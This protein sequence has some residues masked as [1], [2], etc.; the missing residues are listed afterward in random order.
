MSSENRSNRRHSFT[1]RDFLKTSAAAL[2]VP[3]LAPSSVF[4]AYAPSN[5]VNVAFIGTGNQAKNDLPAFLNLSDVQVLAVCDVN[6]GSRG[7]RDP[8]QFLGREPARKQVNDFYAKKTDA[9]AYRGCDAYVDFREVLA[10]KDIDAVALVAPDHWHGVITC[11]AAAAGKDIYCEKPLSL[12]VRQGRAMIDAVRKHQR[13][14]QTGS[15]YRSSPAV[16]R[17]CELVRNGRLGELRKITT[18]VAKN[19]AVSPPP[20]WK[21]MPVPEG[22]DYQMWLGP[23]PDAP[24]HVDR[25]LYR[26]RFLLDYSGGQTTNFG[27]HSNDIAQWGS[28][29]DATLPVEYENLGAEW[30]EP[31]S[32]FTT[33][34]KVDFRARYANGLE[35]HCLTAEPYFG[36]RFEGAEGWIQYDS[37]GIH[38][39]PE[40]LVDS[41]IGPNEI[42]LPVS[43]P[44]RNRDDRK[45]YV[46]DHVRNFVEAVKSRE[47]CIE[48]VEIGHRTAALCHL[49]NIAMKLNRKIRFDPD[50]EQIVGDEEAN[51][52]LDRPLRQPWHV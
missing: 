46:P 29:N 3:W 14:L 2:C 18:Y 47:D 52:M 36:C 15:H 10:R 19:N 45:Y 43:N 48:P 12:T 5:R 25:C 32:L 49:G 27:A 21:P 22:F 44:Q 17:T 16:R 35:I 7:Y 39:H 41:V 38:C 11:M 8:G 42:R 28:G 9:P 34:T 24:Y 23:A 6:K 37:K 1:R 50:K 13:I 30:P 33:A 31:G 4:G 26:F 40:S 20:G 51:A